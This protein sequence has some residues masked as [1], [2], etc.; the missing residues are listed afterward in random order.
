MDAYI[1]SMS[2]AHGLHRTDLN[3]LAVVMDQTNRG[4]RVTPRDLGAVINLS[5]SATS[6]MLDRLERAGHITR[7]QHPHDRRS[8]VV[9]I[10]ELALQ[11]GGQ[12]FGQLGGATEA[13][14]RRYSDE[15]ITVVV[16]FL[17]ELNGVIR[18]IAATSDGASERLPG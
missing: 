14:M 15:D 18:S 3:A 16:R 9:E 7:K 12:I 17:E 4:H 11:T 2:Q 1:A 5:T 13:L 8:V 10:T 6:S